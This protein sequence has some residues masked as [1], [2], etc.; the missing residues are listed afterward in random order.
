[1]K[2]KHLF[3]I[4]AIA[5]PLFAGVAQADQLAD[6]KTRGTLICGTLGTSEP[7]S[8]QDAASRQLVGYDVDICKLVAA[9]L[10]VAVEYKLLAVAARIPELDSGRVDVLAANLGWTAERAAE[11][12]FS[13][14]YYVTPQKLLVRSN[15]DIQTIEDLKGKRIGATK[16]SSSERVIQQT[17]PESRIIG[18]S[19]SPAAFLSLQQRKID[20]QFASELVLAR[21]VNQSPESSPTRILEKA[22]VDEPW[23]LGVRKGED[24]LL[25]E[26]NAALD[27]AETS[28]QA[29]ALFDKWFGNQSVYKLTRSFK[30]E[31]IAVQ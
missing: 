13:H 25:A 17:L 26:V 12:N 21:L 20:A 6:I 15:S 23:G 18:Y 31:P 8:F 28:G 4:A 2:L 16:G 24:A 30:I 14:Q 10:G 9:R 29:V 7:F 22:V 11:I 19:D 5:I 1:M 3:R 27:E